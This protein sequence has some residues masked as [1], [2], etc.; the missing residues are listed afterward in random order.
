MGV[1]YSERVCERLC[2]WVCCGYN[3]GGDECS[4]ENADDKSDHHAVQYNSSPSPFA[5][6]WLT[7]AIARLVAAAQGLVAQWQA[8]HP[9]A[10]DARAPRLLLRNRCAQTRGLLFE[11][12][13]SVASALDVFAKRLCGVLL[14]G[15]RAAKNR[16]SAAMVTHTA[17]AMAEAQASFGDP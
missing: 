6:S 9:A 4:D 10:V 1:C 17:A 11:E 3:D 15:A 13:M 5:P 7:I 12:S 16:A 2:E 14:H 8:R